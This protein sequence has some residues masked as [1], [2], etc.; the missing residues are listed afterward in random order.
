M[1][2]LVG[3][4]VLTVGR[5]RAIRP[6]SSWRPASADHGEEAPRPEHPVHGA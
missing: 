1:F 5:V 2:G 6:V 3:F 4:W